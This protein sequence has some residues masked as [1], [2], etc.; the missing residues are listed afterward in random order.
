MSAGP[1]ETLAREIGAAFA[2][3]MESHAALVRW[4][5]RLAMALR[6]TRAN[7]AIDQTA[8]ALV[9]PLLVLLVGVTGSET[10]PARAAVER[11]SLIKD[12]VDRLDNEDG[13][14]ACRW[15]N[16]IKC[17]CLGL[18]IAVRDGAHTRWPAQAG[19]T[20]AELFISP[21]VWSGPVIDARKAW[22]R[23]LYAATVA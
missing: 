3:E 1:V 15:M 2:A 4:T 6:A 21:G 11:V 10:A 13:W 12:I 7:P 20:V 9:D 17:V 18:T 23:Q 22:L 8:H 19:L 14:P 5:H 16:A